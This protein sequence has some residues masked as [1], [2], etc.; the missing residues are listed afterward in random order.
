[1]EINT[2]QELAPWIA[3]AFTLALSILVPLFTQIANNSFQLEV[4]KRKEEQERRNSATNERRKMYSDFLQDVGA[5]VSYCKKEN[6]DVAG[7]SIQ[8][9]YLVCPQEWW[10]DIDELYSYVRKY[11]WEKA[12][13]ILRKLNKLIAK[14]YAL[15]K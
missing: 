11:E 6:I 5:C 15:I 4:Q 13:V 9:M 12:E 10:K 2:L 8:K 7:A 3:I 14:E 1:M